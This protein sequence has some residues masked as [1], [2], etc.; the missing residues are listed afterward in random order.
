MTKTEKYVNLLFDGTE[1][2]KQIFMRNH[3]VPITEPDVLAGFKETICKILD[4]G[5]MPLVPKSGL[6]GLFVFDAAQVPAGNILEGDDAITV[7]HREPGSKYQFSV[8]GIAEHAL[9]E[10]GEGYCI[11]LFLH[12]FTHALNRYNTRDHH[13]R[14]F[15]QK[16]DELIDIY[17]KNTGE[18]IT[19]DYQDLRD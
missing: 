8:I 11:M 1:E 4:A 10:H 9:R 16:M 19:N 12:E 18:H 13:N 7:W 3:I 14:Q 6:C 2:A 5:I 15:Y 17:N